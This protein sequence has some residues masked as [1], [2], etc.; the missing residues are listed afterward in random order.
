VTI[1]GTPSNTSG[2]PFHFTVSATNSAGT[3]T[4]AFIL[5]VTSSPPPTPATIK[6]RP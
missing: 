2:S 4:S 3:T 1:G 5:T 6:I